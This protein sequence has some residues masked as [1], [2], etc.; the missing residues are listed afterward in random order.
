MPE[1]YQTVVGERG[2][3]LSGGERQRVAIARALLRDAP[4]LVLDEATSSVDGRTEAAVQAALAILSAGRTTLVI[5]HRL[6]TVASAD[7][8]AV[9]EEGQVV[10]SGPPADLLARGGEWSR[11]VAAHSVCP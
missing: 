5:A 2:A 9:L 3:T 8:V 11:H 4:V 7:V 10:E 1:G 6:S